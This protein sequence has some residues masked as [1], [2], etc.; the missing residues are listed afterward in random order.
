MLKSFLYKS[1]CTLTGMYIGR[2]LYSILYLR[3]DDPLEV[4]YFK[5]YKK[6]VSF[7]D[8]PNYLFTSIFFIVTG[9]FCGYRLSN[10][11]IK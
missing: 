1:V 4:A 7:S 11:L 10:K 9:G 2:S 3:I 6:H 8:F 5:T